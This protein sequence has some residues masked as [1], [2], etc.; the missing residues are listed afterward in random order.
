MHH[1]LADRRRRNNFAMVTWIARI[2]F[3]CTRARSGDLHV[4]FQ[5]AASCPSISTAQI[6][7]Q[8]E[9]AG[10]LNVVMGAG[11]R[12]VLVA[13]QVSVDPLVASSEDI[14]TGPQTAV[15]RAAAA[16]LSAA[17]SGKTVPFRHVVE[18]AQRADSTQPST[19]LRGCTVRNTK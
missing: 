8:S 13:G 14:G 15:I 10:S 9:D 2:C 11:V 7:N 4:I 3:Y 12:P 17:V 16:C 5:L 6:N 19:L 18:T 1:K